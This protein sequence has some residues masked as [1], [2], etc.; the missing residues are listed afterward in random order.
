MRFF[1]PAKT[2]CF[3]LGV[4]RGLIRIDGLKKMDG[5]K[6]TDVVR[7]KVAS[8]KFVSSRPERRLKIE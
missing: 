5:L 2:W 8:S 7:D 4:R 3:P 6:K 1:T